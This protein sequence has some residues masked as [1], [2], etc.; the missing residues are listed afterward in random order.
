MKYWLEFLRSPDTLTVNLLIWLN[1][2]EMLSI[3]PFS[4]LQ[5]TC[6]QNT[7]YIPEIENSSSYKPG[8]CNLGWDLPR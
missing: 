4:L 7:I 3:K 8:G 1:I 5:I 2:A 6:E